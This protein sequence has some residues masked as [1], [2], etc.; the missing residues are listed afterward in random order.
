V[1]QGANAGDYAGHSVSGAGDINGDGIADV[2]IG[3]YDRFPSGHHAS[4]VVFGRDAAGDGAF[5]KTIELSA[6]NGSNGFAIDGVK[7]DDH[8][9]QSVSRA[10]DVNGDGID[11]LLIGAHWANGGSGATYVVFG[12]DT[13]VGPDFPA[14]VDLS[15]LDGSSGFALNSARSGEESGWSVSGAGDVNADGIA[16][17][18]IGAPAYSGSSGETYVVYGRRPTAFDQH[19]VQCLGGIDSNATNHLAAVTPDGQA[20]VKDLT[21]AL[22][23]RFA[24]SD[25]KQVV[26]VELM[27]DVNGNGAPELVALGADSVSVEVRDSLTGAK[28][29]SVSFE[30]ALAPIDLE[31]V[32]DR[33]G[34]AIPELANLAR[35]SAVKV[36]IHDA[37]TGQSIKTV[38]FNNYYTPMDLTVY[39][40]TTGNGAPELA[41]LGNH[42]NS[43]NS[44]RIELRDLDT[45]KLVKHIWLGRNWKVLQQTRVA[46]LNGNG[47]DEA[48]VLR[49]HSNG[50]VN[51]ILRD[52]KSG[53]SL[54]SMGFDRNYP[55]KKLLTL[56]DINGNGSDE[57]VVFA[58]RFNDANQKAQIQDSKTRATI[59]AVFFD[60]QF[61]GQD[62]VT[63][64]DMNGNGSGELA[65]LGQRK[66]DGKLRAIVKDAR[67]GK[68]IGAVDF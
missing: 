5:P 50:A 39:P 68:L 13:V 41:V 4:Y 10:G 25:I 51:V 65:V 42:V 64:P 33:N 48:A 3:T 6:L 7:I 37:L 34:N 35:A 38:G 23:S 36:Q 44:D 29:S 28:V 67:T 22:V 31:L 63:C 1:L 60:R 58:G 24:F 8:T 52:T 20:T 43:G 17:L 14:V 11:D 40:D 47:A 32:D 46:D 27:P 15:T 30:P 53:A 18:L 59:R 2:I 57:V 16:D 62:I 56:P 9:G 26:D 54:G 66:S 61:I 21:G 19:R 55:P 49:T 12:R 45:G